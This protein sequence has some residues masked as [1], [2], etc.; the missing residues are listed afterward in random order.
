MYRGVPA[1]RPLLEGISEFWCCCCRS[2]HIT[3]TV[4]LSQAAVCLARLSSSSQIDDDKAIDATPAKSAS[5]IAPQNRQ[6][7]NFGGKNSSCES[8][9]HFT[10]NSYSVGFR[11]PT[12][13]ILLYLVG[14]FA[15]E[16]S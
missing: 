5:E 13:W 11:Q 14:K 10:I 16:A 8:A 3:F 4:S 15:G 12:N 1:G 7:D 2:L 9:G 6:N